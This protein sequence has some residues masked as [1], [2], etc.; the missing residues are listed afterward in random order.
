MIEFWETVRAAVPAG[1]AAADASAQSSPRTIHS[2]DAVAQ[3]CR[4]AAIHGKRWTS[5]QIGVGANNKGS[6][7]RPQRF[8]LD[9][10]ETSHQ[11]ALYP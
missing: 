2:A 10:I 11:H 4:T 3:D 1:T 9:R 8:H 6:D 5:L 7:G